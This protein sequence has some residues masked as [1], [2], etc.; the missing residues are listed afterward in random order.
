MIYEKVQKKIKKWKEEKKEVQMK[1]G[2]KCTQNN[3]AVLYDKYA[4]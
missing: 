2:I 4:H 3:S 1:V